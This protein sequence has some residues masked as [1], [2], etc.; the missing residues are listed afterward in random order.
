MHNISM[1]QALSIYSDLW[2]AY[3]ND[4]S[5]G[6]DTAEIYAYRLMPDCPTLNHDGDSFKE[7]NDEVKRNAANSLVAILNKFCKDNECTCKID[8]WT[9]NQWHNY[10]GNNFEHRCHVKIIRKRMGDKN[11]L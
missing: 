2:Q 1:I 10:I 9:V 4:N 11:Y 5:F 7:T 8:G 3:Y 6:S